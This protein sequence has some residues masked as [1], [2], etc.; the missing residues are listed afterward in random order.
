MASKYTCK[1]HLSGDCCKKHVS[2]KSAFLCLCR[3][4]R[5]Y[6]QVKRPCDRVLVR[7]DGM[8]LSEPELDELKFYTDSGYGA[9]LA[10]VVYRKKV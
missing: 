6:Y 8:N 4:A 2:L 10:G 3:A 5:F 1:G 9:V 7:L